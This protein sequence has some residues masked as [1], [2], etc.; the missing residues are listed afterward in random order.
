[1]T[2]PRRG[3]CQWLSRMGLAA[4]GLAAACLA[5]PAGV[6]AEP[7]ELRVRP[8][9]RFDGQDTA[10]GRLRFRGGLVL[11]GPREFGGFSGLLVEGDR[12]LAVGDD[13][14]WLTARMQLDANRLI[15]IENARLVA[16]R[17]VNGRAI[18][19][20]R[21]GDAEALA[22]IPGGILVAVESSPRLLRYPAQG[23]AV[24]FTAP[25]ERIAIDHPLRIAARRDGLEALVTL[26]DED[27]LAFTEHARDG[28]VAVFR[29][30]GDRM[31]LTPRGDWAVTGADRLPGGDILLLERRWRGGIDLGMRVRRIG[32]DRLAPGRPLDGP[33]LL[34]AD[35]SA[36]IDNMEGIAVSRSE[37]RVAV[38]LISDDNFSLLQRTL[39]LRFELEQ[40]S[41]RPNPR[42]SDPRT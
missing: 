2:S 19:L 6:S 39:L 9:E 14:T 15:G 27:R 30:N 13:G 21:I 42:R 11:S 16:R 35:F 24:D 40:P 37:D 25:A 36:E 3:C 38:T 7:L 4:L 41:P 32:S 17:D 23:I 5:I 34:E 12:L 33:V 18:T 22:R 28:S 26:P 20:K 31:S 1:M 29:R 8:I 10:S